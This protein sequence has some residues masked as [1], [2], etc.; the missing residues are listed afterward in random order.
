MRLNLVFICAKH[1]LNKNSYRIIE[2]FH[3]QGGSGL[4][5]LCLMISDLRVL[6]F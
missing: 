6:I 2:D 4:I 5:L 3:S 1:Q